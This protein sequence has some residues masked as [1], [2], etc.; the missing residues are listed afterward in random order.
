V[1]ALAILTDIHGNLPAL[2]AVLRRIDE[3]GLERVSYDARVVA[4]EVAASGL[5]REFA[6]KLVAAA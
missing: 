1:S 5:P 2:R 3:L 6:D 4:D